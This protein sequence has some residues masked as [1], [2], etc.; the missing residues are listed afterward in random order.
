[1]ERRHERRQAELHA[2]DVVVRLGDALIVDGA[3]LDLRAGELTVLIGPNGAGKTT[4]MRALAGPRSGRR[5]A[6]RS[7]ARRSPSLTPRERARRIAYLP[8]GHVFHWPMPV[9]A[10]VALGRYA[11]G[12]A[13][14]SLTDADRA[15]RRA[16]AGGHRHRRHSPTR[17][18]TTLSGGERA[19]VALARALASEA[20]ILLA[21]EPTVS[22]DPRHQLVVMELLARAAHD[23]GAVLA[24]V[25]DL[26]LA[27]RFADRIVIMDRGRL[28]ADGA[29]REVL[30]PE[31]I[32]AVF[33]VEAVI[34][35]D[36]AGTH[37]IL[38]RPLLD[39][40]QA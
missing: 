40:A 24:I 30:T 8:Q 36:A 2:G 37:P 3:T 15:R 26:A 11:Y 23:G 35:D 25:H 29:P 17:P 34:I 19:R 10:V 31:R 16:G 27:A 28:V 9:A 14:S 38:L 21:D 20:P 12:D 33:G 18:V 39:D 1:M 13:F 4:L 32:A 6:S 22:L 5:A 7:R